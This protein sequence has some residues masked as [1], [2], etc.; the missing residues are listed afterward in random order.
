MRILVVGGAGYIGAITARFLAERGHEVVVLD[1]LTT[2]HRRAWDGVFVE[3]DVRDGARVRALLEGTRFDGVLHFA[4]WS[5]V[6]E[7][8][9]R[10]LDYYDNN[11]GGTLALVREMIA[12]GTE[13]LVFSSSCS[14]YGDPVRLPIDETHPRAPISPYGR[15]KDMVETILEAARDRS[16]LRA[17]TLRYFNAAGAW[18]ERMLGESHTTETHLVPLAIAAAT[19]ATP[20]LRVFGTDYDTKDGTCVRDYVHVLDLADAHAKAIEALA[21]GHE[22]GAYNL[23]TGVGST[24]REVLSAVERAVG[25]PVPQIESPRRAGDPP[26]AFADYAK[27]NRE[28]GWEPRRT[29]DDAVDIR[30]RV[31]AQPRV[32]ARCT[33]S[34]AS[35]HLPLASAQAR[36]RNERSRRFAPPPN[37]ERR[38]R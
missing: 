1:N 38:R 4:A 16:H 18:P 29:L 21:R 17:T 11:V 23:G 25:R 27:A 19:G 32:L 12:T 30:R 36:E 26:A 9:D 8:V 7:S 37:H 14:I 10:P 3:A 35:P 13:S 2:G 6:G 33:P 20:P 15:S 5:L 34:S 28:L 31:G 24:V 22:G